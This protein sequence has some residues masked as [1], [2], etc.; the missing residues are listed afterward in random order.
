M[1][2]VY[3]GKTLKQSIKESDDAFKR[4]G[5]LHGLE[6]LELHEEDPAKLTRLNW[7]LTY[8]CINARE[9]AKLVAASPTIRTFGEC[10]FMLL[11]N[12]GDCVT[13]SLGLIAHIGSAPKIIRSMADLNFEDNPG[14]AEG[15]IFCCNDP[16]YGAPHAADNYVFIPV[17]Y[18]GQLI[19]WA[20]G[21]NHIM[22]VGG[23]TAGSMPTFTPYVFTD[24]CL[25]P[26]MKTGEKFKTFKW[27]D[28]FWERRTRMAMMNVL[29]DR[30]RV[31]GA[32]MIHDKVLE[33]VKEYGVDY[34]VSAMRE[35]ME[36]ERRR[37]V[38]S[39]FT[40]AIPAKF[41]I[42]NIDLSA[43]KGM[44]GKLFPEAD[45]DVL[46]YIPVEAEFLPDGSVNIDLEGSSKEDYWGHN[47]WEGTLRWALPLWYL[48]QLIHSTCV[49]TAADYEVEL[50]RPLGS[51]FNPTNNQLGVTF[52]LA[53]ACLVARMLEF[54]T[55]EAFL[56]RGSV[57]D[58]FQMIHSGLHVD[59]GGVLEGGIPWAYSDFT[60]WGGMSS[61]ARPYRDGDAASTS[62]VNPQS[63]IG[64]AEE[65]ETYEP[66]IV[67]LG[68]NVVVNGC[69]HGKYRGGMGLNLTQMVVKP[70]R[71]S[72]N[73][74]TPGGATFCSITRGMAG[75]YPGIGA[76]MV[77]IH[78]TNLPEL[79]GAGMGYPSSY[80]E[81]KQ[82]IEEGKL[83]AGN[84]RIMGSSAAQVP[85]KDGDLVIIQSF[86]ES[87]WG[88]PLDRDPKLVIKDVEEG[89]VTPDVARDVYGVV[90]RLIPG[91]E[92][93]D[94][95]GTKN[96]RREMYERRKKRAVPAREWWTQE[97][98]K[99]VNK[100]F[101]ELV[102]D[103]YANI[104]DWNKSREKFTKFWQ[105]PKDYEL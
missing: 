2:I 42:A 23:I 19:A 74:S 48:P 46:K 79:I 12:D 18:E 98:D 78:D 87:G 7:S 47:V 85:L 53:S 96:T 36:R 95:E 24:G 3:G 1:G 22:E 37:F 61:G 60:F 81:A 89:W 93:V 38:Q 4:T 83:K 43:Q 28:L 76:L 9:S 97:R 71:L 72:L 52:G 70:G 44:G 16:Y 101:T 54:T 91:D 56:A 103:M 92:S 73:W 65:W 68:K 105:L 51:M 49:N 45:K 80:K 27:W 64:E 5:H 57:E 20:C 99:V 29:D 104:L 13:G 63:D 30:A 100:Q 75:G 11:A 86:H 15:D 34:V 10:I 102:Y 32:L 39:I 31:T 26:P 6:R 84:V 17:F 67:T 82:W 25:Y 41:E 55:S 90:L 8:G 35:M 21:M 94:E 62:T 88:D 33:V 14:I 40:Q 50:G 66:P 77:V 69:A 58:V 59:L